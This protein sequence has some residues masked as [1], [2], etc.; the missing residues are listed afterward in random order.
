MLTERIAVFVVHLPA[1]SARVSR[2]RMRSFTLGHTEE[3][4]CSRDDGASIQE[5]V[6]A[7][8][9]S[10]VWWVARR[11]LPGDCRVPVCVVSCWAVPV[12]SRWGGCNTY[13]G[14]GLFVVLLVHTPGRGAV[15]VRPLS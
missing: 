2:P 4:Y 6:R 14:R 9:C 5:G 1:D 3:R 8:R 15:T 13:S 7:L 12:G 11:Q 10:A